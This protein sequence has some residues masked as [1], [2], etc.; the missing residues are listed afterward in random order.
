MPHPPI[1]LPLQR[2]RQ[3]IQMV[4]TVPVFATHQSLS[5]PPILSPKLQT[6]TIRVTS[7]RPA[8]SLPPDSGTALR[9]P[10]LPQAF[11]PC[12]LLPPFFTPHDDALKTYSHKWRKNPD[13]SPLIESQNCLCDFPRSSNRLQAMV[14]QPE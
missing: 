12:L 14:C 2:N 3:R 5:P 13:P 8:L 9:F 10:P 6:P 7:P 11:S 1:L 4:K